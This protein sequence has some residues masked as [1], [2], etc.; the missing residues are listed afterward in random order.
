MYA[1]PAIPRS[2]GVAGFESRQSGTSVAA[3]MIVM[4]TVRLLLILVAARLVL[5][6][7]AGATTA[8]DICQATDDP[9]VVN[10]VRNG[11]TVTPGSVLDF[12]NRTLR[13]PPGAQLVVS[14]PG[15][16]TVKAGAVDIQGTSQ[17]AGSLRAV[18]G[19]VTLMTTGDVSVHKLGNSTA[20]IDVS[21]DP[22]GGAGGD[23]DIES[24]AGN[25]LL[26]GVLDAGANAADGDGGSV[27]LMGMTVAIGS[28]SE[29]DVN[30]KGAGAGGVLTIDSAS[31][32]TMGGKIDGSGG[33]FDAGEIDLGVGGNL[34]STANIDL[35]STQGGGNGGTLTVGGSV[36]SGFD[37]VGGSATFGGSINLSGDTDGN[38]AGDGGELDI[39]DPFASP[40]RG[41]I[42]ITAPINASSGSGDAASGGAV[43]FAAELDITQSAP[44]QVQGKGA[45]A[46]GG[47]ATFEAHR[48]LTL[49][50]ID[51][52]GSANDLQSG[53]DA[54]AWC[55]L[56]LPAGRTVD[57]SDGGANILRSGGSMLIAGTLRAATSPNPVPARPGNDTNELDYLNTVPV[58]T[59]NVV[60]LNPGVT[61][62]PTLTPCGGGP[63]TCGNG[64]LDGNEVCDGNLGPC[65]SGQSCTPAC[66]CAAPP[67]C[68]DGIVQPGEQCDDGNTTNGD[69]CDN[70]CTPPGCGNGELD[71]GEE[72]DGNNVTAGHSCSPSCK[73]ERCGNGELDPGEQCDDGPTGSATCTK[74]C[75]LMPPATCGNGN[76]DPGEQCDDGNRTDCD[77]CSSFCLVECGD[78][79]IDCG[80]QCDD[81]NVTSNDGCSSTCR[82]EFCGDG[83]VQISEQCD[84]GN[85]N[86]CD[87]CKSDCTAQTVAC[88]ICAAGSTDP[89]VPCTD[90]SDC[91]PMRACG[92]MIC[93]AGVCTPT[94]PPNC[95]DGNPCTTDSCDPARGCVQTPKTCD[96]GDPCNGLST[97]DPSSGACLPGSAPDCDDHDECTD[98]DR[99]VGAGT[100]FQCTTTPRTGTAMATCRLGAID[101]LLTSANIKKST[102]NKLSKLVK[103]VRKKLPVAA[104]SGKKAARA[105]KQ[106]HNALLSLN[107]IVAKAG[108]KIPP[109]TAAN[110]SEAISKLATAVASL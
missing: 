80:E 106:A 48:A 69:S 45:G 85:Q 59:G 50:D 98:N 75:Q 7:P 94:N 110:L 81:G 78:G 109:E 73:I 71:P 17:G 95:D 61:H 5:V 29:I 9:C 1:A 90:V 56:T 65:P 57:S 27:T 87:G 62:D 105:L 77:G 24:T 42:A 4:Q 12:G 51:I 39:P 38:V 101:Q 25:V 100:G 13:V 37:S 28:A 58:I 83:V 19:S 18:D 67:R 22:T 47:T 84:D 54:T 72:C 49:G 44:I 97:C 10:V 82:T 66:T 35:Q 89:C 3:T 11:V 2:A 92:S 79:K 91:D 86:E 46:A 34:V 96:D 31:N 76:L 68:G 32:L 74:D 30:G 15:S 26:D 52:S 99:C 40:V 8:N 33:D 16:M 108:K 102:R 88:P 53:L 55:S 93:S 20:R 23:I 107:R 103:L 64:V 60:P 14:P 41:S 63:P 70:N 104:G 43:S 36:K 6:A 21:G